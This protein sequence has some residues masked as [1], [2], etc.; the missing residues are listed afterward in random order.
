MAIHQIVS[1]GDIING[2][3]TVWSGDG[4]PR[5]YDNTARNQHWA[6]GDSLNTFQVLDGR[7]L[8]DPSGWSA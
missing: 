2:I 7:Y 1:S 8:I 3:A 5:T 6:S 4:V